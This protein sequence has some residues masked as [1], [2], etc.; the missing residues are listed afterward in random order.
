LMI[1]RV[2]QSASPDDLD[3]SLAALTSPTTT[4]T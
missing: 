4:A 1:G 2:D 3:A